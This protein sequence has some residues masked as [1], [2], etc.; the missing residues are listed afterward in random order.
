MNEKT[1]VNVAT[2]IFNEQQNKGWANRIMDNGLGSIYVRNLLF[3][4]HKLLAPN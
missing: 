3:T 4:Q 1:I 2:F